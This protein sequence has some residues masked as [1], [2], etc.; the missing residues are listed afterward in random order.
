MKGTCC[1]LPLIF[2][3]LA[4]FGTIK[5]AARA[6]SPENPPRHLSVIMPAYNEENRIG[7]TLKRYSKFLDTWLKTSSTMISSASILVV[8]DGSTDGTTNVVISQAKNT[9]NPHNAPIHLLRIPHNVGKGAALA[10]A[11]A[12]VCQEYPDGF[13]LTTDADCSA[14]P[15]CIPII[16]EKFHSAF[17]QARA[18]ARER[19]PKILISGARVYDSVSIPRIILRII[20]REAVRSVCGSLGVRDTQC[21]FK[22]FTASA[23]G[24]LYTNMFLTGWSHDVEV[25]YRARALN[26]TVGE[27]EIVWED[28]EGSKITT[29]VA[30]TVRVALTMFNDVV[31]MKSAYE[32]GRWDVLGQTEKA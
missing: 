4:S 31:A 18:Q 20:F 10:A 8:D 17:V 19:Q 21:G 25:Y 27:I 23:A 30:N 28:K 5:D 12:Q 2:L 7:P 1:E 13:I 11:I 9:T 22:L 15:E 29:S 16:Y 26:I 3:V 32:N 24:A 6:F 14:E